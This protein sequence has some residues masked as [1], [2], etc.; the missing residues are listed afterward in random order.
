MTARVEVPP[1]E[2]AVGKVKIVRLDSSQPL[3]EEMLSR[4]P[5]RPAA[6]VGDPW[7]G[8]LSE[9][10]YHGITGEIV[11]AIEPNTEADPV[12]ILLQFLATFG[13]ACGRRCY[14]QVE[15]DRHPAVIWPVLVGPTSKG[16]KGTAW[17]RARGLM[18]QVD[19]VWDSDHVVS[20]L[21]SGEGI[22]HAVRDPAVNGKG[23]EVDP[24]VKD[25]RLLVVESEFAS[26]LRHMERS[27]NILS[28]TLRSFWDSGSSASLTKNSPEKATGATVT[29]IG[30]VTADELR[31]YLTKTERANGLANR[32]LFALVRRSKVLPFGGDQFNSEPF[33][34]PLK[35][36]VAR[37]WGDRRIGWTE[38]GAAIWTDVYPGLSE[39]KPGLAGAITSRAETQVVRLALIYALLDGAAAIDAAH[40]DAA[41]A[42]WR[43]CEQS[44][45][46]I[47]GMLTGNELADSILAMLRIAH[48]GMTRRDINNA[49]GR[50]EES[51]A[52]ALALNALVVAGLAHAETRGTKGRSEERWFA[53]AN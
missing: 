13:N 15:G 8:P 28:S 31:R 36:S 47:F 35:E 48:A 14:Y 2:G 30:H 19:T 23:E 1:P 11:R 37:A 16:R 46:I 40:V 21:S 51:Q 43:Y 5:S 50:H 29:V 20:G 18:A 17:G 4:G 27:G 22:V 25:K 7:P 10:A 3:P 52:I 44:A 32:F 33:V 6:P 49:L 12:A 45:R 38:N 39:G 34:A 41:L 24:G 42:V 26:P 53:D 9:E